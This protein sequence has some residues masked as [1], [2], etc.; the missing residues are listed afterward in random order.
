M[1]ETKLASLYA[2]FEDEDRELA[3]QGMSDYTQG[4]RDEDAR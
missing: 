2:E 3:E 4:L 1:D